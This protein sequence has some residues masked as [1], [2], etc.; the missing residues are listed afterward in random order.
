MGILQE[1]GETPLEDG[2][3]V[4]M[5]QGGLF[6]ARGEERG[7]TRVASL[8]I[9]IA[10]LAFIGYV[11]VRY[12]YF[13]Y[14][15][16]EQVMT[17]PMFGWLLLGYAVLAVVFL[18]LIRRLNRQGFCSPWFWGALI[19]VLA[20]GLRYFAFAHIDYC[21]TS[22]FQNYYNMGVAFTKGDYAAIANQAA[23]Y[24]ISS[25]SGL[26]VLNGLVMLVSGT[27]ARGFQLAQC[28]IASLSC[29]AAYLL[30]RRFDEG[31]APAAGLLFAFYPAN[32]VFSQVTSNQ[33][34]AVLFALLALLLSQLA[35]SQ[36]KPV[37]TLVYS[38]LG[39]ALLLLSYYSHPS[40]ATTL[41]ALG[42]VWFVLL[43]AAVRKR[44]EFLRLLLAGAVFCVG[45]FALRAGTD[46]GLRA[47]G[48]SYPTTVNSS[49]LAKV[50]IGLN[51][52]TTGGYSA[53]DWGMI[54]AQPESE[55]NAFCVQVIQERLRQPDL[56][57]LFDTKLLRMWMVPDG[58]FGWATEEVCPVSPAPPSAE[59]LARDNWLAGAKLLDFFYVALLFVFAWIGGLFR[60]QGSAGD[61]LLWTLM[62]WM[63]VHL[64]IEIQSRYRYFGMPLL[65][66]LA[67]YGVFCLLGG[68]GKVLHRAQ[69][70]T[71]N[72]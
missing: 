68:A 52:E 50:V 35:L 39:G 9:T 55:Q 64:L 24:H 18:V 27:T 45:F 6:F 48:L 72:K 12:K 62:G 4:A 67:A 42:I 61:L 16:R 43:I 58:S 28:V 66:I 29:V 53:E 13:T 57:G 31:S 14:I 71:Q 60:R 10:F 34:L 56:F 20:L 25:F 37:R 63:G 38:L 23:E 32:I 22:D 26:G 59:L 36:T 8:F 2:G 46:A 11:I 44:K 54:W 33:H 17:T 65:I 1:D 51:E 69:P 49:Y 19:F 7:I 5:K 3:I 15:L 41:V 70:N 40:T 21:P 47:A 30:A